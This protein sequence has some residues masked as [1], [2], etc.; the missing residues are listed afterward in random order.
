MGSMTSAIPA[1]RGRTNA[2]VPDEDFSTVEAVLSGDGEAYRV[3]VEK[4][5]DTVYGV[6]RRIVG[7][8]E[9]SRN[10]THET[11]VAA[12]RALHKFRRDARFSTWLVQIAINAARDHMRRRG[13]VTIVSLDEDR[14]HGS[15]PESLIE[16][17][18]GFDPLDTV[19]QRELSERLEHAMTRLPPTYREVFV[20][21]HVQEMSY[22]EIAA[23]TGDNPELLKVRAHRARKLLKRLLQEEAIDPDS[24]GAT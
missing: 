16:R 9:V 18:A 13:R 23:I 14:A 7:D 1:T 19:A 12:Y 15:S 2:V 10:L 11:F 8:P 22:Q 24:V 4:H 6:L 5:Q 17:R 21:R 3:L 20:L